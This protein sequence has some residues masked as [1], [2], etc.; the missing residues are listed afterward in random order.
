M[1][2][3]RTMMALAMVVVAVPVAAQGGQGG[4]PE[5][6]AAMQQR[7]NEMLFRGITL[8]DAQKAKIDSIQTAGREAM[9]SAM[10]GGGM[11]DPSARERMQE[12]REKQMV[13]IRAVLT[14]DQQSI[15]D[16]N[17]ANMPA[18]GQG[19]RPPRQR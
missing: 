3:M 12:M 8:S 2:A 13:E 14:A 6:R 9:R 1:R 10:Q 7:Q 4:N 11:Q 15:F 17:R 16:T 19:R 5:A 18:Q